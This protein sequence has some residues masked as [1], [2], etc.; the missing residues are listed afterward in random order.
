MFEKLKKF[1]KDNFIF[2]LISVGP[3]FG[4]IY[5]L[6]LLFSFLDRIFG[7]IYQNIFGFPVPGAGLIT[8]FVFIIVTGAVAR[9]YIINNLISVFERSVAKIPVANMV[10]SAFKSLVDMAQK[11]RSELGKPVMI[12]IGGMYIPGFEVIS[13]GK[14]SNI[15]LAS[16]F[17]GFIFVVPKEKVI[18][19]PGWKPDDMLKF[20]LSLGSYHISDVSRVL[21]RFRAEVRETQGRADVDQVQ[22]KK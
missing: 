3:I 6:Y 13:D 20:I 17:A 2:G 15:L 11:S 8:L 16:S 1:I 19:L 18:N 12:D 5:I 14:T 22:E 9:T 4:T 7:Q 21:E 10:Y